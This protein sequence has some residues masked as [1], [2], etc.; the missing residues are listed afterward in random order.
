MKS[1]RWERLKRFFL[2]KSEKRAKEDAANLASTYSQHSMRYSDMPAGK[3][4]RW[5]QF[6][7][8]RMRS[9]YWVK[10]DAP[11]EKEPSRFMKFKN[12]FTQKRKQYFPK[13][14]QERDD[15]LTFEERERINKA[16]HEAS[17]FEGGL[18][19][20]QI[21]TRRRARRTRRN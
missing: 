17:L 6:M 7:S 1:S 20:N 14:Q 2:T 3:E 13:N 12:F 5:P 18:R 4:L 15:A 19:R 10:S 9:K 16:A 8:K 11:T 21:R